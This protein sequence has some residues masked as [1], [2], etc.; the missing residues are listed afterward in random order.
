ML[1]PIGRDEAEIRRH[2]WVCYAIFALN[3]LMFVAVGVMEREAV[4]KAAAGWQAAIEYH[5]ERPYLKTPPA[6][7]RLI[8]ADGV[9]YLAE[10]RSNHGPVPPERLASEQR[11]LDEQTAEAEQ[12]RRAQPKYALGYVP[13]EPSVLTAV[14][15]MFVHA[16]LLHLIG[17]LLY[18]F[19]SGPFV[20]DVFGRPLFALLYFGGGI[21][22]TL[23]HSSNHPESLIPSVGAS[24]AIAAV[25]GAY[26]VR[27]ARSKI[28]FLFIPLIYR[29]TW[30]YRF[31]M[32]AFVVLPIWFAQQLLGMGSEE[33]SGVGFSAHV[34]GFVFGLVFAL[35]LKLTQIEEKHVN[36]AIVKETTW[37]LDERVV[38]ALAA[39]HRGATEEAKRELAA[40]LRDG[41][42]SVEALQLAVDLARD[43]EDPAALDAASARLLARHVDQK[44]SVL[45]TELVREVT[46]D[47]FARLPKFLTRAAPY[48]ERSGD[49]EWALALYERLYDTDPNG[50]GAVN[51]L[52]KI[53][54]L[55][56]FTGDFRGAREAL[57]KA[58][59]HPACTA[60]WI[61]SIDA[62]IAQLG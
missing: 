42:A 57:T 20:E 47:R 24:G 54:A 10:Q 51:V 31:W 13:A 33:R 50:M 58:R 43:S 26:L 36:P 30:N 2:A 5:E 49:R 44:E 21:A 17:N 53:G 29:P 19:L 18:L 15:S 59:Q 37:S 7:A 40:V 11:E 1:I 34:G 48:V 46:D 60:E 62:K 38:R 41:N 14:T 27:F 39:R 35:I 3:I 32:P 8:G 25:M 4:K 12:A 55:R 9:A 61:P 23:T 16:G 28:E 22:A 56:R 6:M 45:A 52:M